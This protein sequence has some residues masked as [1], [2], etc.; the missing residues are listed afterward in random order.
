MMEKIFRKS[1]RAS[2]EVKDLRFEDQ[3][4]VYASFLIKLIPSFWIRHL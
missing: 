2:C 4:E 3:T 1:F